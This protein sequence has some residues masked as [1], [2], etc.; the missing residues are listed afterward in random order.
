MHPN[1]R[2][3]VVS[4][5]PVNRR[6][7]S[8]RA[9]EP[10]PEAV[11]ARI[12]ASHARQRLGLPLRERLVLR[13]RP[14][15]T[16]PVMIASGVALAAGLTLLGLGGLQGHVWLGLAGGGMAAAAG[17]LMAWRRLRHRPETPSTT[18]VLFDP[19]DL[20][21]LDGWLAR[22]AP[23]LPARAAAEVK[24]LKDVLAR[25]ARLPPRSEVL[26]GE[27]VL[28]LRESVHRY[29]PDSL[30]AYDAVPGHRRHEI[31]PDGESA[32]SLL[33]AQLAL[34][35]QEIEA[36]EQRLAHEQAEA[37]RSQQRF[38]QAKA[39]SGGGLPGS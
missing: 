10:V 33:A 16:D 35:R 8:I 32:D 31:G 14:M 11:R 15:P 6:T 34:L 20:E 9:P 3:Y 12:R 5:K 4:A 28:Y 29:L 27:D 25:L 30:Q 24:A 17:V 23:A 38:L 19:A 37:L 26:P 13:S 1:D 2:K 21:H 39:R 36:R 22:L 18:Q 7:A